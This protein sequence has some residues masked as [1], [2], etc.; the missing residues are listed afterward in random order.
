MR[1][2]V[3]GASGFVGRHLLPHLATEGW[4]A[5]PAERALDVSDERAVDVAIEHAAPDAVVHLAAIS[6]VSAARHDPDRTRRVNVLGT[7]AVLAAAA[8]HAPNA[9]VLLIGSG[10]QYGSAQSTPTPLD[11]STPSRPSSSYARTKAEAEALGVEY[12]ER[13]LDVVRV[14]AF[15]HAGPGQSD[16]FVVSSFAK[17]LAE[18][19]ADRREPI[20][21]VGNLD[22]VRDFL[23][24]QDVVEAYTRLLDPTVESG[25]YN[26]ASG[27]GVRVGE[28]LEG[29]L[30]LT[31]RRPKVEVDPARFRPTNYSVGDATRLRAATGWRPRVALADTLSRTLEAWR[32]EL[33][34]A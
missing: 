31:P 11:E 3:T 15:N 30:A 25:V 13:G 14:R 34:A 6:S 7:R 21:R 27:V 10:E 5:S 24:V 28:V 26:V 2:L 19:E 18:I 33:S 32:A 20:L 8:R 17:Q 29:L 22:S 16:A 23:D 4:D 1:V 12:A 9:R